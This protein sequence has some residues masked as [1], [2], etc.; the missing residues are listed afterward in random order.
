MARLLVDAGM[1]GLLKEESAKGLRQDAL[2]QILKVVN[3][4]KNQSYS[5][6]V[7]GISGEHTGDYSLYIDQLRIQMPKRNKWWDWLPL[8]PKREMCE[9]PRM[10]TNYQ[11]VYDNL[12]SSGFKNDLVIWGPDR[13]GDQSTYEVA[14]PVKEFVIN[15]FDR[16]Q[17][18]VNVQS[19]LPNVIIKKKQSSLIRLAKWWATV[20][21]GS[22]EFFVGEVDIPHRPW[23]LEVIKPISN[24]NML[25]F[26]SGET[27]QKPISL[28]DRMEALWQKTLGES[29][30]S[31]TLSGGLL[32]KRFLGNNPLNSLVKLVTQFP[33]GVIEELCMWGLI[34]LSQAAQSEKGDKIK[35]AFKKAGL[36]AA[37]S[38]ITPFYVLAKVLR[39]CVMRPIF[40][41]RDSYRDAKSVGGKA[42]TFLK[43]LSAIM[44]TVGWSAMIV[45][46]AGLAAKAFGVTV[47][48][49]VMWN[50]PGLAAGAN[51][52]ISGINGG[53]AVLNVSQVVGGI[54]TGMGGLIM[55]AIGLDGIRLGFREAK[56]SWNRWRA[57]RRSQEKRTKKASSDEAVS[58]LVMQK[59]LNS[60]TGYSVSSTP[61]K[62]GTPSSP[63]VSPGNSYRATDT[64][65][66]G[67]TGKG[68][69][70]RSERGNPTGCIIS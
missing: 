42:G 60:S 48:G 57:R 67:S 44:T 19:G 2:E 26:E 12:S 61:G 45:V 59:G 28:R 1:L 32:A 7:F 62:S 11:S 24:H 46:T 40:S 36:L 53:L 34:H 70:E 47:V 25:F 64:I 51:S 9:N 23:D 41:P 15:S 66:F 43:V 68:M 10:F 50:S 8:V 17:Q 16:A 56:I 4:K 14:I 65:V 38:L 27:V 39:V 20:F 5:I 52:L 6:I 35:L 37:I 55:A 31:Y 18:T 33:L 22:I 29:Y 30:T 63:P 58:T 13:A 3:L 49:N 54:L 69:S 21:R